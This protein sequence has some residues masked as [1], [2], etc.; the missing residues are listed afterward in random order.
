MILEIV[1]DKY[2]KFSLVDLYSF[3]ILFNLNNLLLDS[4]LFTSIYSTLKI[5]FFISLIYSFPIFSIIFSIK[6]IDLNL[7]S[8]VSV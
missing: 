2:L 8:I 6:E 7:S 4:S 3:I 1:R 5:S